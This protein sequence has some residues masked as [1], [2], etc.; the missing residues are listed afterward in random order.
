MPI[1]RRRFT[2]SPSMTAL[3]IGAV[4]LLF[5]ACGGASGP[6]VASLK[7]STTS[8]TSPTAGS[9]N[10]ANETDYVDAVKYAQC[11]RTHGIPNFPDP[12]G[13]GTYLFRGRTVNGVNIRVGL[14]STAFVQANEA[15]EHLLPNGGQPTTAQVEQ[16]LVQTLKYVKCLRTHGVPNMP[17]PTVAKGGMI[18]LRLPLSHNSPQLLRAENAC[19]SLALGA[20]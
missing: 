8:K 16:M 9:S 10:E 12:N 18:S 5:V 13:E 11:M 7:P 20:R 1:K 3:A 15:C 19:K 4:T 14:N 17:D 2:V 6:S